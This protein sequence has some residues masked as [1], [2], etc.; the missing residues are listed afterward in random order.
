MRLFSNVTSMVRLGLVLG[1]GLTLAH[2]GPASASER[3]H[4]IPSIDNPS[5]AVSA[6]EAFAWDVFMAT[7]WPALPGHRGMPD[8]SRTPGRHAT[9][10]W[11]TWKAS[12]EVFLSKGVQPSG[13]D[14]PDASTQAGGK[15]SLRTSDGVMLS[16]S[17]D[18]SFVTGGLRDVNGEAIYSEV[19][20]NKVAFDHIVE[21]E[22]YNVEGQLAY[23]AKHG[24]LKM[25]MG[26]A[27]VKVSWRILDPVKD[28]SIAHRYVQTKGVLQTDGGPTRNV[29][30]GMT[31]M[32][33]MVKVL[34]QWFWTAFE[35]VDNPTQTYDRDFPKVMLA[36]R[37]DKKTQAVNA[38]RRASLAGTPWE[39]YR[40][41][42]AQ[43]AFVDADQAPI[44]LTNTQQETRIL[45]TSSCTGCH[46]Y[47]ALGKVDGVPTRL[48]PLRTSH[49]DGTGTGYAGTPN[50]NELRNYNTLDYMWSFI[51]A[52][53]KNPANG[54]QFLMVNGQKPPRN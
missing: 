7:N 25:P 32:N 13:W 36:V 52:S 38:A 50:P 29:T 21:H 33:I 37:I 51:E 24:R 40:S 48:F 2:P 6:P 17:A 19:R 11:E 5:R 26:S 15:T 45:K 14:A 12:T 31:G 35:Q 54:A 30:L 34:D 43:V 39:H 20:M 22:L 49:L 27:E 53:P 28:R 44:Y 23:L 18:P 16:S 3:R 10:V 42:G 46:A 9:S 1:L 8:P 47:S 4:K 41:N